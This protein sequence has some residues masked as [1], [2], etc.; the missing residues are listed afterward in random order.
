MV[1]GGSGGIG[2]LISSLLS[3][4][5]ADVALAARDQGRLDRAVEE[6]SEDTGGRV[7]GVS[8]DTG[9]DDSVTAGVG[10]IVGRLGGVDILVNTAAT[11][12]PLPR[13]IDDELEYEVNT[14]VRGY[15]RCIRA[16]SPHMVD[17]GWGRIVNLGG[18]AARHM[19]TGI[20]GTVRNV[21]VAAMTKVLADELGP[22]GVN[23]TVLH[24]GW[25][26]TAK[27]PAV[28]EAIGEERGIDAAEAERE[29]IATV[30]IGRLV[31][32]Q[33]VA[34]VAVF[35]AGARSTAINGDAVYAGGGIK[36]AAYY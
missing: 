17:Q 5:G 20:V 28:F 29:Q 2:F 31:T 12:K 25:T 13:F 34:D 33:E 16:V 22:D 15:L 35:L 8:L 26:R 24:P 7:I 1:T 10:E 32:A 21:A 18:T 36:G 3:A 14:K 27:T 9:D 4:E 11:T 30:S 6:I 19:D 23:V